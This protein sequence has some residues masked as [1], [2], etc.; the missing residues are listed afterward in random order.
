MPG[1][2]HRPIKTLGV[3]T[4]GGGVPGLNAAIK[5]LVYRASSMDIRV[6][7]ILSG[8]EGI[9]YLDRNQEYDALIFRED[10]PTTWTGSYL[11]P[12]NLLNTRTIDR[13][14]GTI[15]R[16]TRT[17][18][19][20][21]R[22]GD[23]P[24]HLKHH[25]EGHNESSQVDLTTEVLANLEFLELDGLIVMGGDDTLSYGTILAEKGLPIWG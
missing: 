5:T 17:N 18:P 22:V 7:G 2:L 25:G 16:S 12:L 21:V 23:L 14:G 4:G 20:K 3:L 13:Q 11:M 1:Q 24:A 19:A 6:M 9:T 8:W 10:D 15:L